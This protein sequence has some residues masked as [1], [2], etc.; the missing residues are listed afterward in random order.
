MDL[1]SKLR[2]MT[3][4]IEGEYGGPVKL[5]MVRM[6]LARE[7]KAKERRVEELTQQQVCTVHGVG[8]LI[9]T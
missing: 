7:V 6:R 2:E 9:A 3:S 1:L 8:K 5:D 4:E